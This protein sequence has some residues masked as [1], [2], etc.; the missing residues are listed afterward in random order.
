M[1]DGKKKMISSKETGTVP[2]V[3]YWNNTAQPRDTQVSNNLVSGL[4]LFLLSNKEMLE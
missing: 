1:P 4:S 3:R 2:K